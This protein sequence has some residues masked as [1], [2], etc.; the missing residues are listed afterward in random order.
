MTHRIEHWLHA[1]ITDLPGAEI[2][3]KPE[4]DALILWVAGKQFGRLGTDPSGERILT[5]K[6]DP[7]ENE[8]LRAEFTA[9]VPGYYSNKRHWNSVALDR[10]EVPE[11]RVR[12][13]VLGS[14]AL[15]VET[16]TK[17]QRAALADPQ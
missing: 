15:V 1:L 6:G 16:L 3:M 7:H 17:R 10:E 5:I 2:V 12:E 4:W 8:A 13:M 11:D 9:V 14:Y